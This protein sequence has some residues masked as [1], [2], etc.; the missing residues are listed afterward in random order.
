[1]GI[2]LLEGLLLWGSIWFQ[3]GGEDFKEVLGPPQP[4]MIWMELEISDM[5]GRG[6]DG[7]DCGYGWGVSDMDG[8]M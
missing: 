7:W 2:P 3:T 4:T 5:N 1:M 6:R 8:D